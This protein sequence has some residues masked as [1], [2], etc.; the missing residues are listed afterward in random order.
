[1][2]EHVTKYSCWSVKNIKTTKT[3]SIPDDVEKFIIS[4][5]GNVNQLTAHTP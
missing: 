1:M 5:D 4:M 3:H 2:T